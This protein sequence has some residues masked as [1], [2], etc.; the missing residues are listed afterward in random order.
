V[1]FCVLLFFSLVWVI[2]YS[3]VLARPIIVV[4]SFVFMYLMFHV[5]RKREKRR[6]A[7]LLEGEDNKKF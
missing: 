7:D 4:E 6:I 2:N 5:L 1:G 3:L